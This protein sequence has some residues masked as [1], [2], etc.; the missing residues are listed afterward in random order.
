MQ[1]KPKKVLNSSFEGCLGR[2]GGA[3]LFTCG[4][5]VFD[6]TFG[7]NEATGL[8]GAVVNGD[9]SDE[10]RADATL[11]YGAPTPGENYTCPPLYVSGTRFEGNMAVTGYG[12]AIASI[13]SSLS[14][15]NSSMVDTFGGAVYFGSSADDGRDQ[16]EVCERERVGGGGRVSPILSSC[17]KASNATD[18]C[19]RFCCFLVLFYTEQE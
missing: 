15:F 4:A 19:C 18:Y 3:A 9:L 5:D 11:N 7:S 13:D 2:Y 1:P 10:E 12:G 16:L 14:V 17:E 8:F 6:S